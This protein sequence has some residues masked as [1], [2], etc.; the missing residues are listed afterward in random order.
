[1][2]G[3]FYSQS[4]FWL[5]SIN[6]LSGQNFRH[7]FPSLFSPL[8]SFL[9]EECSNQKF[10][11]NNFMIWLILEGSGVIQAA[12]CFRQCSV[13]GVAGSEQVPPV[14]LGLYFT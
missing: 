5:S 9:I 3:W 14:V 6:D 8:S 2:I 1:M 10:I 12:R 7:Y 11:L 4:L 13:P